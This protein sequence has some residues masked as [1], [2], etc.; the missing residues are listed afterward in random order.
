MP[1]SSSELSVEDMML[2]RRKDVRTFLRLPLSLPRWSLL[3]GE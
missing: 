2:A 3:A 1:K